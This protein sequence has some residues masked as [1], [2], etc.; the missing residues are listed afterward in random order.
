MRGRACGINRTRHYTPTA[1]TT[2]YG[3]SS[4]VVERHVVNAFFSPAPVRHPQLLPT[5]KLYYYYYYFTLYPSPTFLSTPSP[6]HSLARAFPSS[7][8]LSLSPR[9]VRGATSTLFRYVPIIQVYKSSRSPARRYAAKNR[10]FKTTLCT[11][12]L[13]FSNKLETYVS[14]VMASSSFY[15]F[16]TFSINLSLFTKSLLYTKVYT[17]FI[18]PCGMH[19]KHLVKGRT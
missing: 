5:M 7:S 18:S 16:K 11:I 12:F 3:H 4:P 9:A 15:F 1:V 14:F 2:V 10:L 19:Y 17:L 13:Y 8:S 6:S